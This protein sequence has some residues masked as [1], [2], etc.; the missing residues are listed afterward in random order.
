MNAATVVLNSTA[1]LVGPLLFVA[2]GELIAERAG[3]VNLSVEGMMLG[4]AVGAAIA[5]NVTGSAVLGL[6]FGVVIGLLIAMIQA[7]LSHRLTVNQFVIG[8][9]I[10]ILV[11][12][13]TSYLLETYQIATTSLGKTPAIPVLHSIPLIGKAL[14]GQP[15]PFYLLY[16]LIP[17]LSWLLW[18]SRWGLEIRGCGNDPAAAAMSGIP[19]NARRRQAI[20]LCGLCAGFGGAYLSIGIVGAVSPNMTAGTGYVAIAAV[21]VGGWTIR[22]TIL[23]CLLFAGSQALQVTLPALGIEVNSQLLV[24]APYLLALLA[25]IFARRRLQ[26]TAL[27]MSFTA[28]SI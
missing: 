7:G 23:A 25:L 12:G 24:A 21:I 6:T 27:G 26:P 11:L 19:V 15:A 14:F 5:A 13:L 8:I 22:G 16:G 2:L 20:Y 3:T 9:A 17:G 28:H 4:S 1:R 10:N 18:R